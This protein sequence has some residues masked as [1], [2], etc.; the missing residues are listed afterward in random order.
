M[1]KPIRQ[2]P[3]E[4]CSN[5]A[6]FGLRMNGEDVGDCSE[7]GGGGVVEA[8]DARGRFLPWPIVGWYDPELEEDE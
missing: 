7:C 1:L 2:M 8:R 4:Q 5:C 6:G 3:M